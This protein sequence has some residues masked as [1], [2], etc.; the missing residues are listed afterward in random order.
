MWQHWI[1]SANVVGGGGWWGVDIDIG[2]RL[3]EIID[4]VF[5]IGFNCWVSGWCRWTRSD[6][7]AICLGLDTKKRRLIILNCYEWIAF[8][9]KFLR[10]A[11]WLFNKFLE[12]KIIFQKNFV[13][14]SAATNG[15]LWFPR[16]V[17]RTRA[18]NFF[19]AM[20][21]IMAEDNCSTPSYRKWSIGMKFDT[22]LN[23]LGNYFNFYYS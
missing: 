9:G 10:G 14:I 6:K 1:L 11:N 16:H 19:F 20:M 4:K 22:F 15:K 23:I 5:F 8:C 13:Q 17:I 18:L 21:G 2:G 7:R 12:F 3:S